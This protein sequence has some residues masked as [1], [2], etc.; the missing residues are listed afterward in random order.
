MNDRELL[1]AAA[2]AAGIELEYCPDSGFHWVTSKYSGMWWDPL[3][4]D[5]D[6]FRLAVE[7]KVQ[8]IIHDDWVEG[9]IDGIQLSSPQSCYSSDGCMRETTRRAVVMAVARSTLDS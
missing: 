4:V 3:N 8:I 2:K 7:R 1:E 9:L 6:A 5:G